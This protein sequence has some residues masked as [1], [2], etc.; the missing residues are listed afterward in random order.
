MEFAGFRVYEYSRE[1]VAYKE[2]ENV[3]TNIFLDAGKSCCG[4]LTEQVS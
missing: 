2:K 3:D 4:Y 1:D